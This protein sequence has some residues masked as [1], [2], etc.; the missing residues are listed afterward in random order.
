M[1]LAPG[2]SLEG[3]RKRLAVF[4]AVPPQDVQCR[5]ERH[6]LPL[7]ELILDLSDVPQAGDLGGRRARALSAT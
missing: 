2:E 3:I 7:S 6:T 4:I 5:R 1:S